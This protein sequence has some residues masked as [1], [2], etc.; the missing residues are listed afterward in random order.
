V[1]T[2]VR[3]KNAG[4]HAKTGG[5]AESLVL[6]RGED[7][8]LTAVVGETRHVVHVGRCFPWSEPMSFL[9]LRDDDGN[10]IALVR[11]PSDLEESSR[12]ALEDALAEA[13]FVFDVTSV[14]AIDEEVELRDWRVCTRQGDRSFQ[15]R[16]D[17]WPRT[18]PG[19][20]LI[21]RDV[22]G[23]LY[24]LGDPRTMDR[25]SRSLLW[26]FVD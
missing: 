11:H 22:T 5:S 4:I 14:I 18:L 17:D 6:E 19:G 12:R 3:R 15:T 20:G 2:I 26:A 8:R 16:L 25:R 13:D 1:K 7:G 24:K 9:S 23:D 21:I 10:E